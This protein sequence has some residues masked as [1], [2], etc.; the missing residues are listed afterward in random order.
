MVF[1]SFGNDINFF[2]R[3]IVINFRIFAEKFSRD[4]LMAVTIDMFTEIMI[5]GNGVD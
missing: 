4:K 5:G 3:E 1:D 2:W